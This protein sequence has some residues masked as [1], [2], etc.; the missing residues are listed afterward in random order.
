MGCDFFLAVC[1]CTLARSSKYRLPTDTEEVSMDNCNSDFD[2]KTARYEAAEQELKR[3]DA[4]IAELMRE[5]EDARKVLRETGLL[6]HHFWCDVQ[7]NE[8]SFDKLNKGM[9]AIYA[10][11]KEQT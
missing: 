1:R 11:I 7:M 10:A 5:L 2:W 3:R 9:Q 4:R 6:L 8:Y